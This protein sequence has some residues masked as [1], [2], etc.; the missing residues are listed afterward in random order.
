[1]RKIIGGLIVAASVISSASAE[2]MPERPE[3]VA[4]VM[5]LGVYHFANPGLDKFNPQADDMLAEKRQKEILDIVQ[6]LSKFAPTVVAVEAEPSDGAETD[7]LAWRD[8]NAEL[9]ANETQQL[10]FR[11]AAEAGLENV[12]PFDVGYRFRSEQ[13][14][15]LDETDERLRRIDAAMQELGEGFTSEL[16]RRQKAG[17]IGQVLA[18]MNSEEA[19]NANS[20]F[21]LAHTIK[22]WSGDNAGGAHTVANWYTRNLLMFQNLLKLVENGN[23]ERVIVIVGQGHAPILRYLVE[24]SP[25][26]TLEDPLDYLPRAQ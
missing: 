14:M 11:L 8:G 15:A 3:P 26:L 24:E 23:D 17:S 12:S 1:M 7:Y 9:T 18:W 20:D 10:G 6:R 21:Y 22:R 5:I 2:N 13:E 25:W 4:K 16:E 19:L